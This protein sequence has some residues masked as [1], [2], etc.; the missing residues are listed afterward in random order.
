[1]SGHYVAYV[2]EPDGRWW[3]YN[4]EKRTQV[5]DVTYT[6]LPWHDV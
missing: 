5:R 4:D 6:A 1:M 3:E 2:S